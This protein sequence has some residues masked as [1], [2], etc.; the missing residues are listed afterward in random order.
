MSDDFP[1][2]VVDRYYCG[3]YCSY[4]V[5]AFEGRFG[6]CIDDSYYYFSIS[7]FILCLLIGFEF[8]DFGG[9]DCYIG[10]DCR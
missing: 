2:R 7:V 4:A 8:C 1:Q 9:V 6:G 5:N 3:Y 10:Y